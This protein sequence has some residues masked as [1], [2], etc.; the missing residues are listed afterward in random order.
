M[1]RS[2]HPL[3]GPALSMLAFDTVP[4]GLRALDALVKEAPVQV[5]ARGT[6]QPGL[7]LVLI[8]GEV[9]PVERAFAKACQV[10]GEAVRDSVLLP[11]AEERIVPA[12]LDHKLRWPAPGDTLAVVQTAV[13]PTL[14]RAVDAALKGAQVDLIEL[15]VAEGLGGQSLA[16]LWGETHDVQAAIALAD[17]A[18]ARGVCDGS[19]TTIIPNA[20][21]ETARAVQAGTGFFAEWRG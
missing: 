7:Y 8:G 16:T 15:R 11:Y 12:L 21:L 20:D 1:Q 6:V 17:M 2:E 9:E 13:P 4:A 14:L 5:L 3:A 18:M 19:H 10:S